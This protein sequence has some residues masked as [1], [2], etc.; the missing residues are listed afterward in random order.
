MIGFVEADVKALSEVQ[1][2]R[3]RSAYCGL[4]R[5]LQA[6]YGE[7]SRL[8][9]SYDLVFLT[10]VLDSMY[11]P[12]EETGSGR[13]L[14]HPVHSRD[15]RCSRYTEYAA[16]LSVIL[17]R[18]KL[19]DDWNDDKN[20]LARS[21][22]KLLATPYAEAAARWPEQV[23]AVE[24]GLAALREIEQTEAP[25]PDAAANCFGQLMGPLFDPEHDSVWGTG[26]RR[27]GEALGRFIYMMDACVDLEKD[28]RRGSFN[29]LRSLG[30]V[31]E[32]EKQML[33]KMLIGD[34]TA[35]FERLPLVQDVDILRSVLYSGVWTQYARKLRKEK[36]DAGD[37]QRSV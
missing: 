35:E 34:C 23:R 7:L 11:E 18:H 19:L 36:R 20:L 30:D 25:A 28:L 29:P 27:F 12:S 10:L 14:I 32:E 16:D 21:G 8:T 4:C 2:G 33:L 37:D 1:Q 17:A 9:L 24:T 22:A 6:R 26:L 5:T 31:S 15:W 13:C 3:Y